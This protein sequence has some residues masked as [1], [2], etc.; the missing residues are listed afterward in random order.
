MGDVFALFYDCKAAAKPGVWVMF[1]SASTH[2][3]SAPHCSANILPSSM[4]SKNKAVDKQSARPESSQRMETLRQ[5][6]DCNCNGDEE[7]GCGNC[8]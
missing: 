1:P 2:M 6:G 3:T 5:G 4:G 8:Q 7:C